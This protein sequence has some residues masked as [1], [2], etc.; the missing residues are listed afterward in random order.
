[1]ND[2]TL[3]GL[4]IEEANKKFSNVKVRMV[5]NEF[6]PTIVTSDYIPNRINV[7]TKEGRIF[8]VISTG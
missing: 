5:R 3:I 4:T 8:K 1:M 6:G 7:E 2:N